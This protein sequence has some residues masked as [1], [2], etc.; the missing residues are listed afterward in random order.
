[1]I[2]HKAALNYNKNSNVQEMSMSMK[3]NYDPKEGK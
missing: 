3:E 1:M 2:T